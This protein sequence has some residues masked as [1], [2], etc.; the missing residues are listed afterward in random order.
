MNNIIKIL[1]QPSIIK[2]SIL[3]VLVIILF[4]PVL[5]EMY[6]T[7]MQDS[8]NS[9][10]IL[11]PLIVAYLIR[12]R[13]LKDRTVFEKNGFSERKF[14]KFGFI[15]LM[16]SLLFYFFSSVV[17][18]VV[19]KNIAFVLSVQ[20]IVFLVFGLS[21][22]LKF[23]FPLFFL[24]FMIPVP[25]TLYGM[26]SLPMQLFSTKLTVFLMQ[27]T[28]LPVTAA[29]N[30]IHIGNQAL[31][32]AEACS[33]LRSLMSFIMLSLLFAYLAKISFWKKG[34]M[35]G[36]SIPVAIAGNIVRLI[37]T[38]FIAYLYGSKVAA[39]FIHDAS[40]YVMFVV[41]FVVFFWLARK[42]EKSSR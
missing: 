36:L 39:G 21:I 25:T 6:E 22:F 17:D 20:S 16:G 40:G 41:A 3:L 1:R 15:G 13:I 19:F 11:V 32:V 33:G 7:W 34:I 24:F 35:V 31:T 8:N 18:I 38:S 37:L 27:F 14:V 28:P 10:G 5:N 42:L 4:W 26:V 23:L 29:G 12:E 2:F 9:H 30:I